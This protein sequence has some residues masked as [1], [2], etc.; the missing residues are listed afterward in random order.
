M[1]HKLRQGATERPLIALERLDEGSPDGRVLADPAGLRDQSGD[2]LR[3]RGDLVRVGSGV[4]L[5]LLELTNWHAPRI[6]RS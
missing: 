6:R 4:G 2:G 3:T 1:A 5:R